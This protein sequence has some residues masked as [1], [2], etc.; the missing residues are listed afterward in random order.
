M[1][2]PTEESFLRHAVS[3]S[4]QYSEGWR[5]ICQELLDARDRVKLLEKEKELLVGAI[6][7]HAPL[8][9]V[10]GILSA[11]KTLVSID[12]KKAAGTCGDGYLCEKGYCSHTQ[13]VRKIQP[14]VRRGPCGCTCSLCAM[15]PPNTTHQVCVHKC[16]LGA[17]NGG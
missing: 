7:R 15:P 11:A 1:T 4:T 17:R 3:N 2:E 16:A 6:E 10:E 12:E 5:K 14:G 9:D 13:P 8:T